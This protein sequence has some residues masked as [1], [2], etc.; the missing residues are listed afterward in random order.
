MAPK[1]QPLVQR[2]RAD[3]YS[4]EALAARLQVARST[5]SRW[6]CGHT[7]PQPYVRRRLASLLHLSLEDLDTLLT[8][9]AAAVPGGD[10]GGDP[11]SVRHR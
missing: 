2:R 1:R 10:E 6:E 11:V 5:V 3:G 9:Q 8:R 4:Q 7:E